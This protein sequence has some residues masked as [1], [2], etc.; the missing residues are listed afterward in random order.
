M[1]PL[2]LPLLSK[3]SESLLKILPV[4]K[5]CPVEKCVHSTFL[6]KPVPQKKLLLNTLTLGYMGCRI[7][8]LL[9][10]SR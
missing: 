8:R 3:S 1:E 2:A 4:K 7:Y 6:N 10:W 9:L 5:Y